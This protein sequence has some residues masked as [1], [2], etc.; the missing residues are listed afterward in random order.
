MALAVAVV[1]IVVIKSVKKQRLDLGYTESG[2]IRNV[3]GRR[4]L[5]CQFEYGSKYET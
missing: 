5:Y 3:Q 4:R 1:I 2:G